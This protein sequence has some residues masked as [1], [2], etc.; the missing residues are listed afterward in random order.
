[1]V[2]LGVQE[3]NMEARVAKKLCYTQHGF[4]VA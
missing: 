3:S 4:D 2:V 1:M